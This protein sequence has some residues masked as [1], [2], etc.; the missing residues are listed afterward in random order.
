MKDRLY[1]NWHHSYNFSLTLL[2]PIYSIFLYY[3]YKSMY[4]ELS[5][6]QVQ[7]ADTVDHFLGVQLLTVT[8]LFLCTISQLHCTPS[9]S[10]KRP[11]QDHHCAVRQWTFVST[12]LTPVSPL[13]TIVWK[14]VGQTQISSQQQSSGKKRT[15]MKCKVN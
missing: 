12:A 1:K 13:V 11:Q 4:N 8:P 9:I 2:S 6:Y 15:M 14:S 5:C 7:S 3:I 10:G